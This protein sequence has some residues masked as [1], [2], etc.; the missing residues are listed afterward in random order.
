MKDNPLTPAKG[1]SVEKI[2]DEA[3]LIRTGCKVYLYSLRKRWI[4]YG[5]YSHF[6]QLSR[7][8]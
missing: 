6:W 7:I 2:N 8:D 4:E 5:G 1:K 3:Y